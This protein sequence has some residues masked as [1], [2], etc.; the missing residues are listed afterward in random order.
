V[1]APPCPRAETWTVSC[2]VGSPS[3]WNAQWG[4]P[5]PF[6]RKI[7]LRL[8]GPRAPRDEVDDVAGPCAACPA[9]RVSARSGRSRR[10]SAAPTTDGS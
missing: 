1:K 9:E 2:A 3:T 7:Q 10:N 5:R 8:C 6:A 4:G